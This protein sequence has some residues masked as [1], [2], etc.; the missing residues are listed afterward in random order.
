M[1]ALAAFGLFAAGCSAGGDGVKDEGS[2]PTAQVAAETSPGPKASGGL[3]DVRV[4]D[5][6]EVDAVELLRGDPKVAAWLT[7]D[8]EPCT[9]EGYPIDVSYGFLTGGRDPDVVI[10]VLTCTDTVG[11]ASFVYRVNGERYENVYRTEEPASRAVIDRG[12][13]LV[14]QEIPGGK[15]PDSGPAAVDRTTLRWDGTKFDRVH[16]AREVNS[17]TVGQDE[18]SG[19]EKTETRN[20]S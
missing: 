8:L 11:L 20:E 19:L 14:T 10:N 12:D 9:P 5:P 1:I 4:K 7:E 2:A 15:D 18:L 6:L 16:W 17:T 3:T 13:L